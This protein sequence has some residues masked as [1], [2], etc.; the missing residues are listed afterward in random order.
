MAASEIYTWGWGKD[1]QLGHGDRVSQKTPLRVEFLQSKELKEISCGGWHTSALTGEASGGQLF[2]WGSGRCGQLGHG[3]WSSQRLPTAVTN[4]NGKGISQVALGSFHTVVLS[5]GGEVYSWGCGRDGQLGHGDWGSPRVPHLIKAL[6]GKGV[7]SVACGEY[8]SAAL[9]ASGDVY[10]W[11]DGGDGQLGHGDWRSKGFRLSQPRLIKALQGKGVTSI[12]CGEYHMAALTGAGEVFTWGKSV[13]GQLG[14]SEDTKKITSPLL[15]EALRSEQV[16]NLSCGGAHT[17]CI[18]AAGDVWQWGDPISGQLGLVSSGAV[19]FPSKVEELVGKNITSIQCGSFHTAAVS[20]EGELYTWGHGG[21]GRLGHGDEANQ[22]KPR[23]V[24][25]LAG[26]PVSQV[27]CGRFH[28]SA[29]TGETGPSP[30]APP[31]AAASKGNTAPIDDAQRT[32]PTGRGGRATP[33]RSQPGGRRAP[34]QAEPQP[35]YGVPQASPYGAPG[36]SPA[37]MA[38]ENDR[39]AAQAAAEQDA[40]QD[41]EA[42]A[43]AMED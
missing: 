6:Q 32:N 16:V 41:S 12:S 17:V 28:T 29:C 24:R 36:Q 38:A 25:A 43:K 4:L 35:G 33:G 2:S 8:H 22:A 19:R 9:T 39:L 13:N 27:A 26:K 40:L 21:E 34:G 20:A 37:G 14:H 5:S 10:T 42:R 30:A 31:S 3:D 15:V 11:G 23:L 1:G 18:T 7:V